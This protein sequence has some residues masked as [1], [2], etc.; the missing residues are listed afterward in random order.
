MTVLQIADLV[1]SETGWT[2]ERALRWAQ[3]YFPHGVAA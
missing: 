3:T 1:W 2:Y